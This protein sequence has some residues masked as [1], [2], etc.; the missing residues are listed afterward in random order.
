MPESRNQCE[1]Q[2]VLIPETAAAAG[3]PLWLVAS[4]TL[5]DWLA[6][7]PATTQAWVK[8]QG[9]TAAEGTCLTIPDVDGAL[10]GVIV[11]QPARITPFAPAR[12]AQ[13]L[14]TAIYQLASPDLSPAEQA[15]LALGWRLGMYAFDALRRGDASAPAP[16][17]LILPA[18]L[19]A[20]HIARLAR[21]TE[22][23]RDLVNVPANHLG[24]AELAEAARQV[25][26]PF[27]NEITEIVG[28]ALLSEGFP[29]VHVVGQ[30][31]ERAPRLL[32]VRWGDPS[33][34]KIAIVGKGVVFDTGGYNLKP[35]GGMALMKKDMGGAAHALA[36]A[37]MLMDAV[38]P[39]RGR[40]L[41]PIVEN[42]ISGRAFRPLDII[43]TRKGSTVEVGNTDAEGRLILAD[44]LTAGA[45]DKPVIM[46]DFATLTGA[47]RVALGPE[48]PPLFATDPV[49]SQGIEAI[50]Q[51]VADLVWPM[52]LHEGYQA[53]IKS[54]LADISSTGSLGQAG[55]ITAALFLRHFVPDDVPWAH[56]D[57]FAW[58]QSSTNGRAE[59]GEAW[60]ARAVFEYLHDRFVNT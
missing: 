20:A 40:L 55:A 3:V 9:F 59:G 22:L 47:A 14:P 23:I 45:E 36:V 32:D 15:H 53:A 38:T 19:D 27:T 24:P 6:E 50:G 33:A 30:G 2:D 41:L 57:T 18:G 58:N 17:Q 5:A 43:N 12:L 28:D 26:A 16:P 13:R 51:A 31:S 1:R 52:P 29:A 56:I 37:W 48:L 7:Q 49:I 35:T 34:P 11:G 60:S 39:V 44:A 8:A 46:I 4:G 42:S 10:A 54:E 21:G 25:V